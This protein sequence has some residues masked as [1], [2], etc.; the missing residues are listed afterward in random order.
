MSSE[1]SQGQ[2][3]RSC[4]RKP[5]KITGVTSTHRN[6]KP[7]QSRPNH[8]SIRPHQPT[9]RSNSC[10]DIQ[11]TD[12]EPSQRRATKDDRTTQSHHEVPRRSRPQPQ[13]TVPGS[14]NQVS[15]TMVP[16]PEMCDDP[17][18]LNIIE[19][20]IYNE[21]VKIR[22]EEMLEPT[23]DNDKRRQF[24]AKIELADSIL[25]SGLTTIGSIFG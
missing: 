4:L 9:V 24:S 10:C 15:K 22:R 12:P 13:P 7:A 14:R 19:R 5:H 23:P 6:Q 16:T 11:N 17:S 21:I 18:T 2:P 20:R 8:K 25:Q 3:K 1:Q